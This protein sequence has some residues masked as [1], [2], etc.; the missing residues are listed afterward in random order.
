MEP[1]HFMLFIMWYTLLFIVYILYIETDIIYRNRISTKAPARMQVFFLPKPKLHLIPLLSS[2]D[3][4]L[5]TTLRCGFCLAGIKTCS[6]T[7]PLW[8]RLVNPGLKKLQSFRSTHLVK[9]KENNSHKTNKSRMRKSGYLHCIAASLVCLQMYHCCPLLKSLRQ[10][11]QKKNE[12]TYNGNIITVIEMILF[13]LNPLLYR[14]QCCLCVW[15]FI[16]CLVNKWQVNKPKKRNFY[17]IEG[18]SKNTKKT[19]TCPKNSCIGKTFFYPCWISNF[20]W[21]CIWKQGHCGV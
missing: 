19:R 20:F 15:L 13:W 1:P 14:T 18:I 10:T 6:H 2:V 5:Q 11:F 12:Q 16:I 17:I 9:K 4:H 8:I 7:D 21:H 3:F